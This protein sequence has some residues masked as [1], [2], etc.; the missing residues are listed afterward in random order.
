MPTPVPDGAKSFRG[1]DV[2]ENADEQALSTEDNVESG[3]E[4][5]S[6]DDMVY[7]RIASG[8]DTTPAGV[9]KPAGQKNPRVGNP[10]DRVSS[11]PPSPPAARNA[12]GGT[13][14]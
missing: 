5:D 1:G 7:D 4:S 11:A 12:G 3:G 13:S 2:E 9:K 14:P 10:N 6:D 8:H